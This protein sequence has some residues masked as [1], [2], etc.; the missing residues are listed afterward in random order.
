MQD[1]P[2]KNI[3]AISTEQSSSSSNDDLF[4]F[5]YHRDRFVSG[6]HSQLADDSQCGI[7]SSYLI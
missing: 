3:F 6:V 7:V 5:D 4:Q 2:R 1:S